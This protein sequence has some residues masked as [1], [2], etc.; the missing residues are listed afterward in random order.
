MNAYITDPRQIYNKF[1]YISFLPTL[2]FF[3][4]TSEF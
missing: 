1:Y 4:Q 3:V 2:D